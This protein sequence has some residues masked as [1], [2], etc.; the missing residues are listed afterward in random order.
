L[1]INKQRLKHYFLSFNSPFTLVIL[2]VYNGHH[3]S[4]PFTLATRYP[5][6]L[7]S[8]TLP[9]TVTYSGRFLLESTLYH[10]PDEDQ[11]GTSSDFVIREPLSDDGL[12][13]I[14]KAHFRRTYASFSF[15]RS[16][17]F[18]VCR[19]ALDLNNVKDN[20]KI[21]FQTVSDRCLPNI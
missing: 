3:S 15:F 13:C 17:S 7:Q 21:V 10:P 16:Q 1:L 8:E 4:R 5:A 2:L 19:N 20:P 6:L 11:I 9:N 14:P 12:I 18:P